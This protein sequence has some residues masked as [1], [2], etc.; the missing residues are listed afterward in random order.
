MIMKIIIATK[1]IIHK[2]SSNYVELFFLLLRYLLSIVYYPLRYL[3]YKKISITS[4]ISLKS[5]IRNRK[6]I[7]I[8]SKVQINNFV[9]LWPTQLHIGKN[10]QINPGTAI[11]GKVFIGNFVMI[12]PN[13]MLAGGNHNFKNVYKPMIFQGSNEK[14]IIIQDDVWVGANSTILDGV[15]IG[16]G[17]I[18]GANTLV[19]KSIPNNS[20]VVGNPARIIKY[21][22]D[23]Q[24]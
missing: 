10:S 12:A 8:E 18:I 21:R 13:C 19:S 15:T 11:Y 2:I 6:V 16:K 9:V 24:F 14:G 7:I 23:S 17:S 20:I 3:F 22:I 1:T 4:F 5:S